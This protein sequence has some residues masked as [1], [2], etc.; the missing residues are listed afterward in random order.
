MKFFHRVF[1]ILCL[2]GILL[3]SYAVYSE[4][5]SFPDFLVDYRETLLMILLVQITGW[6]VLGVNSIL[7]KIINWKKHTLLRFIIGV[8]LDA[9]TAFIL[10]FGL[11]AVSLY[12][13]VGEDE[14]NYMIIN[15]EELIVKTGIVFFFTAFTYTIVDFAWFSYRQYAVVQIQKVQMMRNQLELQYD[16]LKSQLSPHYLFNSL[17]TISALIYRDV[18]VA[19]EFIRNFALTYQYVLETNNKK[20]VALENEIDFIKSYIFLLKVRFDE[21]LKV[22]IDIPN[23]L[24]TSQIP[25]LTLQLLI[26]NAVKHNV[27]TEGSPLNI[28]I[29][30]DE[31]TG[32]IVRNN[33]T[34]VPEST[35]SFK[36]GLANIRRRY[37]YFS[38]IPVKIINDTFFTV[39]LPVL[40]IDAK[41]R[42]KDLPYAFF[43]TL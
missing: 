35:S 12:L 43:L 18:E 34:T 10:F 14:L 13:S 5:S 26:E 22:F 15:R 11:I 28:T 38:E 42:N 37:G 8:L 3:Y 20:L 21:S 40:Y 1:L 4:T 27:I 6:S 7:S 25:P 16:M 39:V 31:Q 29:S 24:Y 2:L 32:L 17:N 19:E 9:L 41:Q 23:E 33:K 36:V 30:Y